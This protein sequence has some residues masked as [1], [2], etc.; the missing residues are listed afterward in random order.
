MDFTLSKYKE[1]LQAFLSE[2]YE[3][4]AVEDY[5]TRQ[6]DDEKVLVLRH[7]VD[8][9][10]E[11]ALEIARIEFSLGIKSTFYFRIGKISNQPN[12][13]AEIVSLEHELGY[14]YENLSH[15]RGDYEKAVIDF[16]QNL[17][18]FREFYPVKTVCMHGNSKS[19]FDNKD[20]WNHIQLSDFGL[21]GEPYL[22]F[23]FD[24]FYYIKDTG[25]CFDGGNYV[26]YDS[27]ESKF[28]VPSYHTT[29]DLINGIKNGEL[30]D[31]ILLLVHTLWTDN[32]LDRFKIEVREFLKSRLKQLLNKNKWLKTQFFNIT[33]H[34][35]SSF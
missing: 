29:Q 24:K 6:P 5:L 15:C 19:P 33:R 30:P 25:Y 23:D 35:S 13:I 14:H 7:D 21:I 16:K 8:E 28:D 22:S 4:Y 31:K 12:I 17:A 27:V 2:G 32:Q 34:F 26:F 18:Y 10:P 1:L 3:I 11:N 9:K 20:L